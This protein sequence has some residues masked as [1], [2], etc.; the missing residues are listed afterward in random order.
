M[1]GD[2][3]TGGAVTGAATTAGTTEPATAGEP[4]TGDSDAGCGCR[5]E[6][7]EPGEGVA[8]TS[9]FVLTGWLLRRRRA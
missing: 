4:A 7:G 1:T 5:T 9:L 2:E 6:G 3:P 8:L